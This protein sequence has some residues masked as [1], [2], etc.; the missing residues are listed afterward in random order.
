MR[1]S[2]KPI[3]FRFDLSS[4]SYLYTM[5]DTAR[6]ARISV[7]SDR[8]LWQKITTFFL[9]KSTFNRAILLCIYFAVARLQCNLFYTLLSTLYTYTCY[10]DNDLCIDVDSILSIAPH[11]IPFNFGRSALA[12]RFFFAMSYNILNIT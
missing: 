10:Y 3:R 4:I 5:C 1:H 7:Q 6:T 11:Y 8:P 12:I 9:L 2:E